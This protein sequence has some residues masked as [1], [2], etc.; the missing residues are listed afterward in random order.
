MYFHHYTIS[1]CCGCGQRHGRHKSGS[2]GAMAGVNNHGKVRK[3]LHS[4][5]GRKI[6]CVAGL[7]C[8]GADAPLAED[9]IFVALPHDVLCAHQQ[10]LKGICKTALQ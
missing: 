2:T 10:F 4:G 6:Q 7:G 9:H 5:N 3:F 1:P 8:K